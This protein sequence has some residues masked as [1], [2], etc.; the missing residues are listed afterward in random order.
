MVFDEPT[1]SSSSWIQVGDAISGFSEFD[2]FGTSVAMSADG[3][4]IAVGTHLLHPIIGEPRLGQV[5]MLQQP[6]APGT[7]WT[8][9]GNV[10]TGDV[11]FGFFGWSVDMAS[12]GNHVIIGTGNESTGR[13]K[14]FDWTGA[15]WRQYGLDILGAA[16]D[17]FFGFSVAISAGGTRVAGGARQHDG[18]ARDSG[19]VRVFDRPAHLAMIGFKSAMTLVARVLSTGLVTP[20]PCP[21]MEVV[22]LLVRL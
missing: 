4:R 7:T 21:Q 14:V 13:V 5:R 9:M 10:I 1:A 20:W 22:S 3:S 19:H 12:D 16:V 6:T 17:D 8:Q 2:H 18:N 15:S 11:S